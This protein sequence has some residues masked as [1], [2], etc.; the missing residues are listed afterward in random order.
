MK[1]AEIHL[2][3]FLEEAF[4]GSAIDSVLYGLE[5]HDTVYRSIT[6]PAGVRISEAIGDLA[7]GPGGGLKELDVELIVIGYARVAGKDKKQRQGSLQ[8]VFEIQQAVTQLLTADSTFGGRVCD[9]LL[10][11]ASRGYEVYDGNPYAVVNMPLLINPSGARY[12]E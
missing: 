5:L 10:R 11:R 9:S 12:S 8:Q 2:F 1:P 3:E 6:K 4:D 7:P